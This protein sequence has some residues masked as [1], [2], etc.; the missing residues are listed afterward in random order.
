[1]ISKLYE[2]LR[3]VHLKQ[4]TTKSIY[5]SQDDRHNGGSLRGAKSEERNIHTTPS[6]FAFFKTFAESVIRYKQ[7][8]RALPRCSSR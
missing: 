7:P 4:D 3:G 8:N 1:V 2:C 6:D 5:L